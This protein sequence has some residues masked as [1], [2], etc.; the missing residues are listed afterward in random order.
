MA[1]DTQ[2]CE[3]CHHV[4]SPIH[5][6]A[7]ALKYV[8]QGMLDSEDTNAYLPAA[9]SVVGWFA[10]FDEAQLRLVEAV[11]ARDWPAARAL[12]SKL[13]RTDRPIRG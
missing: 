1:D 8:V 9:E 13:A 3:H 10:G 4:V 11:R 12:V 5:E 6:D 7:L 2:R